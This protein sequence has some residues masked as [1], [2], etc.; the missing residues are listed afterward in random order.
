MKTTHVPMS[1]YDVTV[2]TVH[3]LTPR[4]LRITFAASTL[5]DFADD[6]PDQRLKL[7]LPRQGQDRPLIPSGPDGWY[8]VWR[9]MPHHQR[10][11]LRT[12]T[13]R[14]ARPA[15][16]E[17]DVDIVLHG[18]SGPGTR[19]AERA[20]PGDRVAI[21]AAYADYEPD[22]SVRQLICGD[23]T[24]LP[25]I[26]AIVERLDQSCTATVFIE[27]PDDD[28]RI[29][30]RA[31]PKVDVA[32]V[33]AHSGHPGAALVDSVARLQDTAIGDYAWV[34]G[35]RRTATGIR[36]HLVRERNLRP[37]QVM[38]M[39]YWRTDGPIDDD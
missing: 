37:E 28:E 33:H 17:L 22:G 20:Q 4:M 10:P 25:A 30:L 21:H 38:F 3:P 24:A 11:I 13:V 12:Y 19:W 5:R 8:K 7:L 32:W 36:R 14:N 29:D 15:D 1:M 2:Q 27:V 39:G 35:E 26:S 9:R 23:L 18:D 16:G 34:A 6:G 31:G